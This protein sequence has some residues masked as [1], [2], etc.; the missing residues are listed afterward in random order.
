MVTYFRWWLAIADAT[1]GGLRAGIGTCGEL[2]EGARL[3]TEAQIR[4]LTQM[5][6]PMTALA[7]FLLAN[8]ADLA[9]Q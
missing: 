2:S 6:Q 3:P 1:P 4:D 9:G 5:L 7:D 8:V